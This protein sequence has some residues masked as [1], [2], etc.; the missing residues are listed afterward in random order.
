[1][2]LQKT[3]ISKPIPGSSRQPVQRWTSFPEQHIDAA[4]IALKNCCARVWLCRM[5]IHTGH[6]HM[7]QR[8]KLN[9]VRYHRMSDV[10]FGCSVRV[11]V[12]CFKKSGSISS[13]LTQL[14][15]RA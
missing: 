2:P 7:A 12:G 3:V 6:E 13:P 1:M 15:R 10:V 14:P 11:A 9:H 5:N 4:R 8:R